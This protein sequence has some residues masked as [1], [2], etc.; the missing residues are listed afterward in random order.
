GQPEPVLGFLLETSV[1]ERL[2]GP[3][4]EAVAGRTGSQ[5]L[6]G[7]LGRANLFVVPLGEGRRWWRYRHLFAALLRARLG[8][9]RPQRGA[10]LHRAGAAWQ[11][12]HGLADD[13]VRHALAA[14]DTGWAARLVE[15]HFDVVFRRAGEATL[16]RWLSAVPAEVVR[17]RPRLCLARAVI[18]AV[19]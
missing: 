7:E 9:G 3:L 15:R 17:V 6:L 12:E 5:A 19:D 10:G 4:C 11:E 16:G 14:G 8:R 18:A 1:L 2:C 13:A